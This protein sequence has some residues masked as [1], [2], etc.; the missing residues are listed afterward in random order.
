M[1]DGQERHVGEGGAENVQLDERNEMV[2]RE[3]EC[4]RPV[5]GGVNVLLTTT[6]STDYHLQ[7]MLSLRGKAPRFSFSVLPL[8]TCILGGWG[9]L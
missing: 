7:Y 4:R 5:R 1:Q 9:R 2:R 6:Q 3:G 8:V